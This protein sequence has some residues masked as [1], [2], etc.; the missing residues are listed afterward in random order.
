MSLICSSLLQRTHRDCAA[1]TSGGQ[2]RAD[3]E[4]MGSE[5]EVSVICN[6]LN[7]FI[8]ED[9]DLYTCYTFLHT[10]ICTCTLSKTLLLTKVV[11]SPLRSLGL[12]PV[13]DSFLYQIPVRINKLYGFIIHIS[14][15][16]FHSYLTFSISIGY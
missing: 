4:G 16:I 8:G 12:P 2:R 13:R 6:K 7:G 1:A 9:V 11:T 10:Y 3:S 14:Y 5:M 15:F